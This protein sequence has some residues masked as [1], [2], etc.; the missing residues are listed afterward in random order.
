MS[1]FCRT[2]SISG[3]LKNLQWK[4]IQ[5]QHEKL[6]LLKLYK[7]IHRIFQLSLPD[8]IIPAA[9]ATRGNSS[10]KLVATLSHKC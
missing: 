5:T 1:D 4:S 10:M 3:I 6:G 7:I 8:Y 2:N 9:R